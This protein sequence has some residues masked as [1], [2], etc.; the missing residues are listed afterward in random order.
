M[1]RLAVDY[2]D[3]LS[4]YGIPNSVIAGITFKADYIYD[5]ASK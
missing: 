5:M 3:I 1:F 2:R 4:G